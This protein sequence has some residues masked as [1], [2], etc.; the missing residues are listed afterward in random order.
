M[1]QPSA[2]VSRLANRLKTG[3]WHSLCCF[4]CPCCKRRGEEENASAAV[5]PQR[6]ARENNGALHA[7]SNGN[8]NFRDEGLVYRV[9]LV[10]NEGDR[11]ALANGRPPNG[12]IRINGH[13]QARMDNAHSDHPQNSNGARLL[14]DLLNGYHKPG[15]SGNS[16][17]EKAPN[18][19]SIVLD[20]IIITR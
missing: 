9:R 19:M 12:V 11:P 13:V 7:G 5:P 2:E 17:Q 10:E 18:S 1:L 6:V 8:V 14:L 16:G 20:N 4:V 15:T 3:T